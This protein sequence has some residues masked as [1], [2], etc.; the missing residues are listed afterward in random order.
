MLLQKNSVVVNKIVIC[1]IFKK[2]FTHV[3]ILRYVAHKYYL[4]TQSLYIWT[5]RPSGNLNQRK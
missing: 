4:V 1:F 3:V 2:A 5:C